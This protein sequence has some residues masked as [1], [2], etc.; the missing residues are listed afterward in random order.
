M[1]LESLYLDGKPSLIAPSR[2]MIRRL[3]QSYPYVK[4]TLVQHGI[5]TRRFRL[6]RLPE[7]PVV[8]FIGRLVLAKGIFPL[9]RAAARL[10]KE[11]HQDLKF[12]LVG[13][14]SPRRLLYEIDRLK[15]PRTNI[16]IVGPVPYNVLHRY[17][18]TA[19]IFVLPSFGEN[20]P[21]SLLEAMSSGRPVIATKTGGITEMVSNGREGFLIRMGDEKQIY[22]A[23]LELLSKPSKAVRMGR[24]GRSKVLRYFPAERMA[25][26]T[27]KVYYKTVDLN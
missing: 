6:T 14:G 27:L 16:E 5:D 25:K 24:R 9:I 18:A 26:L 3:S 10:F 8:L 22:E 15:I 2:Y 20:F 4:S 1:T 17:I 7:Q 23:I 11:G 13:G 21:L 12:L 19:S